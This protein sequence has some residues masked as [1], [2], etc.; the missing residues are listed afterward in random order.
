M[1]GSSPYCCRKDSPPNSLSLNILKGVVVLGTL[2]MISIMSLYFQNLG[3]PSV[4]AVVIVTRFTEDVAVRVEDA[5]VVLGEEIDP[6]D[7]ATPL[8]ED[9][10]PEVPVP[11]ADGGFSAEERGR[12]PMLMR[13]S[14]NGV[15]GGGDAAD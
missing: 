7:M 2:T 9:V 5:S 10:R 1:V 4:G 12:T 13:F 15:A 14:G 3:V 6:E 8:S 11:A